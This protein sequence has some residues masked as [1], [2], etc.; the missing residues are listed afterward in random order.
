MGSFDIRNRDRYRKKRKGRH[1]N[2]K[3][4]QDAMIIMEEKADVHQQPAL[5]MLT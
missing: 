3:P 4:Q 2:N 5:K 1:S